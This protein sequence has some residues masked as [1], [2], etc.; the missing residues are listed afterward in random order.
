V[1]LEV[2]GRV[3]EIKGRKVTVTATV[4]ALGE[5]VARGEVIAIQMPEHL[6]KELLSGNKGHTP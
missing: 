2:R 5:V 1:P 6:E 3:K 4:S